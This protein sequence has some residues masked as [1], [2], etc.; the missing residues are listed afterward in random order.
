MQSPMDMEIIRAQ[1][2]KSTLSN[3]SNAIDPNLYP[4]PT[5]ELLRNCVLSFLP[6]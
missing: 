4:Y 1:T 2:R 6:F 3:I 5:Y